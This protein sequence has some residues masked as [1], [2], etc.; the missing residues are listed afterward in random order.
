[1]NFNTKSF[2]V[3]FLKLLTLTALLSGCAVG[4]P[5]NGPR[6][7]MKFQEPYAAFVGGGRHDG[8]D[9]D[10]PLGTPV[11]SIG[12]GVVGVIMTRGVGPIKTNFVMIRHPDNTLSRYIHIDKITVKQG[13]TVKRGQA[14]AVTALNGTSGPNTNAPVS[15][16]H[17]HL[18]IFRDDLVDPESLHMSCGEAGWRWPVGC[19]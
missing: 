13:E 8:L 6:F 2:K 9:L 18:E 4:G 16:P 7:G 1:M 14:F 11:R 3:V 10:V 12:D 15:Y 5:S 17:L 19:D